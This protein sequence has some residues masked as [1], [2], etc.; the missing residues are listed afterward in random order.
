MKRRIDYSL[1]DTEKLYDAVRETNTFVKDYSMTHLVQVLW[2]QS[3]VNKRS[4][5]VQ[6]VFGGKVWENRPTLI[7]DVV[8][9]LI[10][11]QQ[12][13]DVLFEQSHE[14]E[15]RFD[16]EPLIISSEGVNHEGLV[17]HVVRLSV[18]DRHVL[19]DLEELLKATR[20]A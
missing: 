17:D 19:V 11:N 6:I 4:R 1:K 13:D 12:E 5:R 3:G 20:Y 14:L 8:E 18:G 10:G 15:D 7:T 16:R 2:E 9:T